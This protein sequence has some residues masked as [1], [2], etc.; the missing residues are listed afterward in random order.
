MQ[1][2]L[3]TPLSSDLFASMATGGT[4]NT[5]IVPQG[6]DFSALLFSML[7]MKS[8]PA[9]TEVSAGDMSALLAAELSDDPDT[10]PGQLMLNATALPEVGRLLQMITLHD[11]G[12]QT[13][14]LSAVDVLSESVGISREELLRLF[15]GDLSGPVSIK[16]LPPIP[17]WKQLTD[18]VGE[19][20][21]EQTNLVDLHPAA[22]IVSAAAT[23]VVP[24]GGAISMETLEPQTSRP[25]I[26]DSGW[27]EQAAEFAQNEFR[28]RMAGP[29]VS[30][31]QT[32]GT[33]VDGAAG[34]S[35]KTPAAVIANTMP[36][37]ITPGKDQSP[38]RILYQA[39]GNR[40]LVGQSVEPLPNTQPINTPADSAGMAAKDIESLFPEVKVESVR[41]TAQPKVAANT[42]Q[43]PEPAAPKAVSTSAEN[44]KA[45]NT[46]LGVSPTYTTADKSDTP[47][48]TAFAQQEGTTGREI[49]TP[50]GGNSPSYADV[51]DPRS[52]SPLKAGAQS[53][54]ADNTVKSTDA[55]PGKTLATLGQTEVDG[56][57]AAA[58]AVQEATAVVKGS[59]STVATDGASRVRY[60][61]DPESLR[62]PIK[63]PVEI[64]LKIH[65]EELGVVKL[66][67]RTI[68][69]HLSARVI[70]QSPAARMAVEGSLADLQRNL[71]DAGLVVDRFEV[72]MGHTSAA[73]ATDPDANPQR[74]RYAFKPKTNRRYQEIAG[75]RKAGL[76]SP[77]QAN[78]ATTVE[79]HG[80]LNMVA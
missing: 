26:M 10:Q 57:N 17:D 62:P 11:S 18:P 39:T 5:D 64:H 75:L 72:S 14:D 35:E 49:N 71:A 40:V 42:A 73:S 12:K 34:R 25:T 65:P 67:L 79:S 55:L 50:R 69:N 6:I 63:M 20:L 47:A 52:E 13:V 8:M 30:G 76:S 51:V 74:R 68:D 2:E 38:A 41:V 29:I 45:P 61:I 4:A 43:Q 27:Q 9:A 44:L 78:G 23:I 15:A 56:K 36:P 33:E 21:A 22:G 31:I 24:Q 37:E 53:L 32:T 80:R 59:D 46:P 19:N 7:S 3:L 70:V 77:N 1:T 66:Q 54:S 48:A 58:T 28:K 60:T 16:D